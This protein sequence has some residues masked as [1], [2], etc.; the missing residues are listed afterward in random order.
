M[1]LPGGGVVAGGM[2]KRW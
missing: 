2:I 1:G